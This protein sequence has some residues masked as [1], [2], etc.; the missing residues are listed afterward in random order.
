MSGLWN[1]SLITKSMKANGYKMPFRRVSYI[2][3]E[4]LQK[5]CEI[6]VGHQ[7]GKK[8]VIGRQGEICIR[9]HRTLVNA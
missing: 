8:M 5:F 4:I 1:A 3:A 9:L 7:Y 2:M 6:Q